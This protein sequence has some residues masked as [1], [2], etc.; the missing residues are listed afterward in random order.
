MTKIT[1]AFNIQHSVGNTGG[2]IY[3]VSNGIEVLVTK[4]SPST[5]GQA[6]TL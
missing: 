5:R 6:R 4:E 1:E 2:N 3:P